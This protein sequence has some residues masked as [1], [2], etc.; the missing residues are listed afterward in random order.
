MYKYGSVFLNA[1]KE[2]ENKMK[3]EELLLLLE[4]VKK[5]KGLTDRIIR[6]SNLFDPS[7]VAFLEEFD[8][9][10]N[11]RKKTLPVVTLK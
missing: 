10:T 3:D 9:K 8:S 7:F 5:R 2:E 11:I 1:I 6:S 4:F